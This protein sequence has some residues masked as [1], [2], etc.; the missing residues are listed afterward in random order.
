MRTEEEIGAELAAL[1][2]AVSKVAS[3]LMWRTGQKVDVLVPQEK[4]MPET[5]VVSDVVEGISVEAVTLAT[6]DFRAK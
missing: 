4:E 6:V 3:S 5:F 2:A 1:R